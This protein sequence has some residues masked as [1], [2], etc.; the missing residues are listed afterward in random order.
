VALP[1]LP[2]EHPWPDT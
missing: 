2:D 1:V